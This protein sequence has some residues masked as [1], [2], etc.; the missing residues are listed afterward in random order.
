[1]AH[2]ISI[3]DDD[4]ASREAI[5]GLVRS[6]GHRV[7]EFPGAAA[8]L[9]S[10]ELERTAFLIADL[11]MPGMTGLELHARLVEAGRA[12]PTV[13]V[14]AYPS[15]ST[16]AAARREGVAAYFAKPVSP[17]DLAACLANA[18]PPSGPT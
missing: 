3:V 6:L 15:E 4:D 5:A 18:R 17:A 14:T 16:R 11:S 10:D 12:V 1:M 9:A 2:L 7:A 8:F 13:L